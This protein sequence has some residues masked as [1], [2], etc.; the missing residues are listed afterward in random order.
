MFI[1]EESEQFNVYRVD[2][3]NDGTSREIEW[4]RSLFLQTLYLDTFRVLRME[5]STSFVW[6][7][8]KMRVPSKWSQEPS[9]RWSNRIVFKLRLVTSQPWS[10]AKKFQ[11]PTSC[12]DALE[13]THWGDRLVAR[14]VVDLKMMCKYHR[15]EYE[16]ISGLTRYS[17]TMARSGQYSSPNGSRS[18]QFR[19]FHVISNNLCLHVPNMVHVSSM[20]FLSLN[21]ERTACSG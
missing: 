16:C 19:S 1:L 2:H 18:L 3:W 8:Q 6:S 15:Y 20:I 4:N 12:L 5:D 17:K 7:M 10:P 9:F 13:K 14:E 11:S 21:S